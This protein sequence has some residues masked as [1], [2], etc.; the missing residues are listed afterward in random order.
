M[1]T[2]KSQRVF[3]WVI[4][5]VMVV[6]TLAGFIAMI[7]APQNQAIDQELQ[8]EQYAKMMAEQKKVE[9]DRLSKLRPLDGYSTEVFDPA[10]V[11]DLKVETLVEGTGEVIKSDTALKA[12]N[13]FGWTADG[14]IFDG[15]NVDGVTTPSDR[16]VV[17]GLIEGWNTALTGAKIG[18]TIKLTIPTEQAY[19]ETAAQMGRPVG[20]LMFILEVKA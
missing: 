19:G 14:K 8:Q 10:S 4:A 6:G 9:E 11:T 15:T 20:P 17:G 2:K 18:S 1:A 5:I 12:V 3:I 16:I 7:L 13:Y